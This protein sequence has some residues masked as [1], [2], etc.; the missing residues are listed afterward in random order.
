MKVLEQERCERLRNI[1]IKENVDGILISNGS[2]MRYLS[3]FSGETGFL[4]ITC[5]ATVIFTD[6]RYTIQARKRVKLSP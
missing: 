6:S 2:N 4:L 1:L 3:G 5:Q